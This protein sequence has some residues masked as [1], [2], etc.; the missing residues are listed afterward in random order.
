MAVKVAFFAQQYTAAIGV[1]DVDL[2]DVECRHKR[3]NSRRKWHKPRLPANGG[4]ERMV[5]EPQRQ[6]LWN[7]GFKTQ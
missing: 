5:A 2:L 7:I 6:C 4:C 3:W 1:Y